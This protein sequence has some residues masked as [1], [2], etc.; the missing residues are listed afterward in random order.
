MGTL[1]V[2]LD[3]KNDVEKTLQKFILLKMIEN[4]N[5]M[6]KAQV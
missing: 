1:K 2:W 6:P 5:A 4:L 3:K